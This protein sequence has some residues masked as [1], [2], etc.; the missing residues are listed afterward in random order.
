MNLKRIKALPPLQQR[1]INK[2]NTTESIME[3]TS[4]TAVAVAMASTVSFA[5]TR[6]LSNDSRQIIDLLLFCVGLL[7]ACVSF[8]FLL[9]PC[10]LCLRRLGFLCIVVPCHCIQ[11]KYWLR[12]GRVVFNLL[13]AHKPIPFELEWFWTVIDFI[14]GVSHRELNSRSQQFWISPPHKSQG[15]FLFARS[16]NAIPGEI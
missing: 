11:L 4:A 1:T 9:R 10:A 13:Q 12:F 7:L 16:K 6:I 15:S 14:F 3:M 8:H 5:H 2:W